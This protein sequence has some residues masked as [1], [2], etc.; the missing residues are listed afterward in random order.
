MRYEVWHAPWNDKETHH[1][2]VIDVPLARQF[3]DVELAG[4]PPGFIYLEGSRVRRSPSSVVSSAKRSESVCG[5]LDRG[6]RREARGARHGPVELWRFI[7]VFAVCSARDRKQSEQDE[8]FDDHRAPVIG[9]REAGGTGRGGRAGSDR[10][11][12]VRGR[13]SSKIAAALE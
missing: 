11:R 4:I 5:G 8:Y 10:M 9:A 7:L 1:S 13:G 2:S 3:L 12:V 6:R